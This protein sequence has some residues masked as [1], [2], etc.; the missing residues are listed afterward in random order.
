MPTAGA[1][2]ACSRGSRSDVDATSFE[3]NVTVAAD[4]G[5]V[6]VMRD[7]AVH[8]ARYAGCRGSDADAYGH[9]VEAIVRACFEGGPGG[10]EVPVI[11]RRVDGPVE[12]LI[13]SDP[14]ARRDWS[15]DPHITVG[16]AQVGDRRMWCVARR[17]PLDT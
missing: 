1:R 8:A 6:P 2:S 3:L 11:L 10:R 13:A 14:G 4:P 12:F 7:L 17:M 16:E 9:V 15:T 5:L